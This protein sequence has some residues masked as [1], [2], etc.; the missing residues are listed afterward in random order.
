MSAQPLQVLRTYMKG[1]F[2]L[3]LDNVATQTLW[4]ECQKAEDEIASLSAH[5]AEPV[6]SEAEQEE[7]DDPFASLPADY[8]CRACMP[9]SDFSNGMERCDDQP[10]EELE[11]WQQKRP[12][13]RG[14]ANG[15]APTETR[16]RHAIQAENFT[17]FEMCGFRDNPTAALIAGAAIGYK[18]ACQD[19]QNVGSEASS[20]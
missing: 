13:E 2:T 15:S 16:F 12:P 19:M 6:Q 10:C 4:D 14:G 7:K 3:D 17:M 20:E 11:A 9:V 5:S 1:D 18:M 8:P